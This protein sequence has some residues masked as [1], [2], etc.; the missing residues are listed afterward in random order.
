MFRVTC[1]SGCFGSPANLE[2][3]Y[4]VNVTAPVLRTLDPVGPTSLT[5]FEGDTRTV[6][7]IALDDGLPAG[8]N[9]VWNASGPVSISTLVTALTAAT[10]KNAARTCMSAAA[11]SGRRCS[12][13]RD[14]IDIQI[15]P[16]TGSRPDAVM[17]ARRS[18]R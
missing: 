4:T 14:L 3:T 7:V 2:I 13:F 6:S 11:T 15:T 1:T 5:V 17:S 12:V 10:V 16:R 8:T 9:I 18:S